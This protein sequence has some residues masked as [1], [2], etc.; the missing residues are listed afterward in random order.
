M[1]TTDPNATEFAKMVAEFDD[2]RASA[3]LDRRVSTYSA[4]T[5][6]RPTD[7]AVMAMQIRWIVEV[8][9]M[10]GA[11][12]LNH[13]AEQLEATVAGS[14]DIADLVAQG[15]LLIYRLQEARNRDL[16]AA[17]TEKLEG[18]A[19]GVVL[20]GG[21]AGQIRTALLAALE[22]SGGDMTEDD[23]PGLSG[24]VRELKAKLREALKLLPPTGIPTS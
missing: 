21:D 5:D 7:P 18:L 2:A 14:V 22:R 9:G 24:D 13:V 8:F 4:L 10:E 11:G 20:S 12:G 23:E 1:T 15:K 19:T 6:A 17:I 16:A 3:S